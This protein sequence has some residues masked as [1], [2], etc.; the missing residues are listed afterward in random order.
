MCPNHPVEQ[1]SYGDVEAFLSRLNSRL[2]T[3]HFYR[4]PTEAEW[5]Y[6]ARAGT[7][8]AYSFGDDWTMLPA[9][10]VFNGN[11]G[12]HPAPVG[13]QRLNGWMNAWGLYDM[14]GN[15]W[16]WT[17]DWYVRDLGSA[18]QRDPRGPS[19]GSYRVIRGGGW[20][21]DAGALRSAF[22]SGVEPSGRYGIVGLRLVRTRL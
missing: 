8:T 22:R 7:Q 10:A 5:E 2:G 18:F 15:V 11:S 1:V 21:H 14:H 9:Y 16:E 19:S 17:S 3:S 12:G 4:L 20:D 13:S 6:A